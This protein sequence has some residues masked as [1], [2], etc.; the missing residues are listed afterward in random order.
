M[1][2]SYYIIA[3]I[4]DDYGKMDDGKDWRGTRFLCQECRMKDG[5]TVSANSCI[6]KVAKD[7]KA[8][9][10]VP[11]VILFDRNGRAARVDEIKK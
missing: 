9:M 8:V 6:I 3:A 1:N 5:R 10:G 7:V 2:N 11:C 4:V